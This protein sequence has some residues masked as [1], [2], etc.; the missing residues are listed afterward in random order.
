MIEGRQLT[1][2]MIYHIKMGDTS[3]YHDIAC[4]LRSIYFACESVQLNSKIR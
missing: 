4:I 3:N 2:N 1:G